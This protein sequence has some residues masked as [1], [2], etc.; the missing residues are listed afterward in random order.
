MPGRYVYKATKYHNDCLQYTNKKQVL[1]ALNNFQ[2]LLDGELLVYKPSGIGMKKA[3]TGQPER[4]RLER[5]G[6]KSLN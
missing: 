3:S 4:K 6:D 5:Q 1:I 2:S